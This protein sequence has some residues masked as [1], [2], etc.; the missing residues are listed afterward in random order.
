MTAQPL[1]PAATLAAR[2]LALATDEY[3][4]V[5]IADLTTAGKAAWVFD[6]TEPGVLGL[7]APD[8]TALAILWGADGDA[9]DLEVGLALFDALDIAR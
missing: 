9:P 3:L 2:A 5:R 8:G 7:V 6:P 1:S 4:I